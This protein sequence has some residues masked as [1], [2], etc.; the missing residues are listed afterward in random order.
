MPTRQYRMYKQRKWITIM[1]YVTLGLL[2]GSPTGAG[3]QDQTAKIERLIQELNNLDWDNRMKAEEALVTIGNQGVEL[4]IVA[5]KN[6]SYRVQ[7]HA[8]GALG[9]IGNSKAVKPL[10]ATLGDDY[11]YDDAYDAKNMVEWALVE[12]GEPSVEPLIAALKDTNWHGKLRE[13]R[14]LH[15]IGWKPSN[16]SDKLLYLAARRQWSELVKVGK[17]AEAALIGAL[18]NEPDYDVQRAAARAL[19]KIGNPEPLIAVL[20]DGN[21]YARGYSVVALG[22]VKDARAVEP[23]IAA[24]KDEWIRGEA[25][26]ALGRIGDARAI[27]PLEELAR[28]DSDGQVQRWAKQS[29]AE[30]KEQ[31][32]K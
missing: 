24:L 10:I 13:A 2:A 19:G 25:V 12:I 23:L 28:N 6:G 32:G 29:L 20:K 27:A 31:K 15:Q 14:A 22:L 17:P 9:R 26:I 16:E 30:I 4:L 1:I 8:A 3:A 7:L 21:R 18:R 11:N 5:L